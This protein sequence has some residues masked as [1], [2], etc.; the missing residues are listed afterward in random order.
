MRSTVS[1]EVS[2]WPAVRF[3]WS[4]KARAWAL[5]CSRALVRGCDGRFAKA[6]LAFWS[7][8]PLRWPLREARVGVAA[9]QQRGGR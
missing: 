7:S 6:G 9:E 2:V 4:A 5:V 3:T 8:A 1:F